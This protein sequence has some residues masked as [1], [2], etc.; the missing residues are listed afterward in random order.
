MEDHGILWYEEYFTPY[1]RFDYLVK[2]VLY[3]GATRFQNVDIVDLYSF[4]KT[5]FLDGKI[6][7]AQ[8]DEAVYHESLVHPALFTHPGPQKVLILGGGEGATLRE[9]LRHKGIKE[10]QMVDIDEEL[11]NLCREYLPEWSR[12]AFEDE[13]SRIF[14]EDARGFVERSKER[15]DVIISDLTEPL[16][17]GPSQKLFTL[18]FYK[19]VFDVLTDDG[20]LVVQSGAAGTFYNELIASI[21]RTLKEIFPVVRAYK[22]FVFSFQMTWGFVLASRSRDPISVPQSEIE[23]RMREGNFGD[24]VFFTPSHFSSLFKLPLYL[25][26]AIEKGRILTDEK[27]FIW[28]A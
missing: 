17:G 9:V 26:K 14:Y 23:E 8:I 2:R 1:L 22:A 5:L 24:L 15:Y 7:S 10:V 27:P 18:E 6:Q 12:G 19:K 16:E 21:H 28:T 20:I 13:R 25:L 3:Q 11:V 4:G